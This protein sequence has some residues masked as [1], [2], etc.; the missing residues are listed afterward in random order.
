MAK[1][2]GMGAKKKKRDDRTPQDKHGHSVFT[3]ADNIRYRKYRQEKI[4]K[5]EQPK[6]KREWYEDRKSK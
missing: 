1:K 6:S 3:A 2:S 5:G 4:A